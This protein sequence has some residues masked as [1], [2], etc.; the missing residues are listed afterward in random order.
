MTDRI[1]ADILVEAF[2]LAKPDFDDL[3]DRIEEA[4]AAHKATVT[5]DGRLYPG[6]D[7]PADR[8]AVLREAADA[9]DAA[10]PGFGIDRYVRHGA[11]L[12]R[13]MADEAQQAGESRG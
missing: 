13:R 6:A 7:A 3:K 1:T 11:D 12:L 8:A 9:I 5:V 4:A 2:D 10:F